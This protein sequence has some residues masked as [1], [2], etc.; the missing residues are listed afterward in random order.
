[1]GVHRNTVCF[2]MLKNW[3][4]AVRLADF[5][6]LPLYGLF[7]AYPIGDGFYL[8]HLEKDNIFESTRK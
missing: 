7:D 4:I 2:T 1:M 3:K 5:E 8:C 6:V